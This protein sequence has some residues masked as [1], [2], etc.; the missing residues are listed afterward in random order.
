LIMTKTDWSNWES[1]NS[2][3]KKTLRNAWLRLKERK[4]T[5]ICS[6]RSLTIWSRCW[7]RRA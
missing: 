1:L 7:S 6:M 5:W 2:F 3:I 4:N